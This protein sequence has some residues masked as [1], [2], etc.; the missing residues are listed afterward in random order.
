MVKKASVVVLV[1]LGF[2]LA[3]C[4]SPQ[5]AQANQGSNSGSNQSGQANR[6]SGSGT[7]QAG[8]GNNGGFA[9]RPVSLEDKLL[10]GTLDLEATDQAVT[11]AQAKIL[12]P[13]WQQVKSL[14]PQFNP[15]SGANSSSTGSS[16]SGGS[17]SS[18]NGSS[19]STG[20][21]S[22]SSDMT[23]VLN[24]IQQAMSADQLKAIDAMHLTNTDVE[25]ELTELGVSIPTPQASGNNFSGT[26]FP[27]LSADQ[28]ATRVA[29]R[30]TQ[31]AGGGGGG[32][33]GGG[34]GGF[35]GTPSPNGTPGFR[36]GNFG[37][38]N[39]VLV[40]AV[41]NLLTQRVGQ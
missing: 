12:L 37:G 14:G 16:S 18:S 11:A 26:P 5:A 41:I 33:G 36:G 39:T 7:N 32:N 23:T 8:Q 34:F 28:R 22:S 38:I 13:L 3:A 19:S 4:S 2:A 40:D 27:T 31:A 35:Q 25:S 29:E 1:V 21:N 30:Q 24:Q 10:V 20:S 9:A 17:N 15:S 6:G